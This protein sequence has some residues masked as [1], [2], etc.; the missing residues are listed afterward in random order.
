M[1]LRVVRHLDDEDERWLYLP[2]LDL[3]RRIALA[4]ER[5]SFVGSDF[6]YEDISGRDPSA[7]KHTLKIT[8]EQFYVI[9]SVA[10]ESSVAEFSHYRSWINKITLLPMKVDYFD[11]NGQVY[12][13]LESLKVDIIQGFPTTVVMRA[14]DVIRGSNTEIKLQR[15]QYDTD[16]PVDVFS[17][18]RLK[19]PPRKW[20]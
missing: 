7:D 14:T 18:R 10:K 1:A 9:E 13:R 19:N 11:D 12:R 2:D 3:V 6:F 20:L 15:V 8:T 16:L 17:E 4:D 5:T